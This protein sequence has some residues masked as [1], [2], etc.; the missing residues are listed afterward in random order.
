MNITDPTFNQFLDNWVLASRDWPKDWQESSP[1]WARFFKT[2]GCEYLT[3]TGPPAGAFVGASEYQIV[4]MVGSITH[5]LRHEYLMITL[6]L[7]T[8]CRTGWTESFWPASL[9]GANPCIEDGT[10]YHIKPF[11]FFCPVTC[12]CRSGDKHC[13]DACPARS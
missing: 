12:G 3:M 10:I 4:A 6:W 13:P 11:S 5:L 2:W 8:R 7:Y 1:T 9:N